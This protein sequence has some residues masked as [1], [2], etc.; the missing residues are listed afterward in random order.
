MNNKLNDI[1]IK[2]KQAIGEV[3]NLLEQQYNLI[4]KDDALGLESIISNIE[5]SNKEIAIV[6]MERRKITKGRSMK[7][8]I[9][10]YKD[11]ELEK[12]YDDCIML[13]EETKMQKDSNSILLKQALNYTNAMINM[14]KPQ[15]KGAINT[16][17]SYGKIRR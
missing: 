14:L 8:V 7:E 9:D 2:E 6:E 15:D 3:L 1:L 5:K 10:E 17:N 11:K 13:L 4:V 16:Y 12:N